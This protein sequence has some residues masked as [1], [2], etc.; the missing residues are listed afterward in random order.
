MLQEC[1]VQESARECREADG[2]GGGGTFVRIARTMDVL[3]VVF[4][5]FSTRSARIVRRSFIALRVGTVSKIDIEPPLQ[6]SQQ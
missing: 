2:D 3:A 6:G 1:I 4:F 5:F